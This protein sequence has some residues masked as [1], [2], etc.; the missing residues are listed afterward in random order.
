[1]SYENLS[2]AARNFADLS[3][4]YVID[5]EYE[6]EMYDI[7]T[8]K[9]NAK[10]IID[11]ISNVLSHMDQLWHVESRFLL[12]MRDEI[13]THLKSIANRQRVNQL[14]FLSFINSTETLRWVEQFNAL[15]KEYR[16]LRHRFLELCDLG[17][18]MYNESLVKECLANLLNREVEIWNEVIKEI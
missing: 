17:E 7:R 6:F 4:S 15:E 9:N 1:M 12:S 13:D 14:L 3:Y 10:K 2:I 16:C 11:S 5:S 8:I 18:Y